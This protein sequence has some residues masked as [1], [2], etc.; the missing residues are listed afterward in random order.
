MNYKAG[1]GR[2]HKRF[3]PNDE[4]AMRA[5]VRAGKSL[6]SIGRLFNCAH[7]TV[8]NYTLN[9]SRPTDMAQYLVKRGAG[10]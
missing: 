3:T 2:G 8:V 5:L 4:N 9:E 6:R 7:A 1:P 10:L